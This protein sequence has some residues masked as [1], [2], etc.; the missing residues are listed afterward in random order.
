MVIK[1]LAH[2]KGDT[3]AVATADISAGENVEIAFLDTNDKINISCKEEIPLGHKIAL[4]T[5][6][7]AGKIIEYGE[8]IGIAR[9]EIK[10]G[11]HVHVHNIKSQ[12]W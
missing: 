1:G 11:Q 4:K 12:R 8:E 6:I 3:V 2:K 5:V 9:T 7:N 10:M